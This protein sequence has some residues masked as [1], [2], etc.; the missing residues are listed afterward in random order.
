MHYSGY[1]EE[2]LLPLCILLQDHLVADEIKYDSLFKKYE[3]KRFLQ[4]SRYVREKLLRQPIFSA[5]GTL[6]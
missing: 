1:T 2:E 6:A 3:Q 4:A 5:D